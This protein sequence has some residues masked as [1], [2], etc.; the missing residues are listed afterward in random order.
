MTNAQAIK[1]IKTT[2][3]SAAAL[4][5]NEEATLE[6]QLLLQQVLNVNRAWLITHEHDVL[7]TH[8]Q[9]TFEALLQR[10]LIG[11]PLAIYLVNVSFMG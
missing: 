10:R 7:T 1:T 2:L 9:A 5:N 11:E 3:K 6:A 8:Q 4:L